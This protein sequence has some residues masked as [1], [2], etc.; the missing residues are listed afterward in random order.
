MKSMRPSGS[1]STGFVFG[2]LRPVPAGNVSATLLCMSSMVIST[3]G[4]RNT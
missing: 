4:D 2:S 3:C 1:G